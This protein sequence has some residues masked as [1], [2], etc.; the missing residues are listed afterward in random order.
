MKK[1]KWI[2]VL[3][4]LIIMSIV[5][6][7]YLYKNHRDISSEEASFSIKVDALANDFKVDKNKAN[8]KYL[9]KTMEV[10]GIITAIDTTAKTIIIE[11]ILS[12]TFERKFNI[13]IKVSEMVTIKGRFIGYDELLE[14]YKMDQ[15]TIIK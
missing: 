10:F 7:N 15:V 14:E 8:A 6:Y 13:E 3:A 1:I 2:L 11:T 9:D 4:I 5:S 12:A